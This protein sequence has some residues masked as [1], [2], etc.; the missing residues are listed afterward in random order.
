MMSMPVAWNLVPSK[1]WVFPSTDE[2][3]SKPMSKREVGLRAFKGGYHYYYGCRLY[4]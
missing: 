1:Y 2:D 4:S 3:T